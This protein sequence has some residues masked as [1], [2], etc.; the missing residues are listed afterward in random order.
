LNFDERVRT[1]LGA[2]SQAI[3]NPAIP[4]ANH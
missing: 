2:T 3:G 1:M 4:V